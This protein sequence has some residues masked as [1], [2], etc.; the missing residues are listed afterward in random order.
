MSFDQNHMIFDSAD[1]QYVRGYHVIM[2]DFLLMSLLHTMPIFPKCANIG[3][4]FE[5]LYMIKPKKTAMATY[6]TYP[7]FKQ[8]Y[9]VAFIVILV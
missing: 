2:S 5:P 8:I 9:I 6:I 3:Q 7:T 1:S 4:F